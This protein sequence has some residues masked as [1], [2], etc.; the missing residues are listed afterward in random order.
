VSDVKLKW[1]SNQSTSK[2]AVVAAWD[3]AS[4]SEYRGVPANIDRSDVGM[5]MPR[6]AGWR[7]FGQV[8]VASAVF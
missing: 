4:R 8:P 2:P 6:L 1:S 7:V 5:L 3:M